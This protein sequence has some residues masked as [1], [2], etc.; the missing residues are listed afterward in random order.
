MDEYRLQT[1]LYT[2]TSYYIDEF[3]SYIKQFEDHLPYHKGGLLSKEHYIFTFN[4]WINIIDSPYTHI[5]KAD[6]FMFHSLSYAMHNIVKNHPITISLK[7]QFPNNN[8]CTFFYSYAIALEIQKSL[9]KFIP[10]ILIKNY[11]SSLNESSFFD[12]T[13]EDF[14]Q[15]NN[16]DIVMLI[17]LVLCQLHTN[18]L[19]HQEI[20]AMLQ[21]SIQFA[22]EHL[23]KYQENNL[24]SYIS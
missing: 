3:T 19:F 9:C 2:N 16:R 22:R 6:R 7:E 1:C 13:D 11:I 23:L 17:K 8:L 12:Q 15:E 5:V 4:Y 21:R 20:S 18:I 24:N 10:D 14:N